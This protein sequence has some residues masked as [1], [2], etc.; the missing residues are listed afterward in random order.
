MS[1]LKM[2]RKKPEVVLETF[3]FSESDE[4]R[5]VGQSCSRADL[6]KA[7]NVF[8]KHVREA[9][10]AAELHCFAVQQTADLVSVD[11][12]YNIKQEVVCP[13]AENDLF[14]TDDMHAFLEDF[15]DVK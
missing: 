3:H 4:S 9:K 11:T 15:F 13:E 5:V 14:T 10:G 1:S 7:C 12:P 2:D 6:P 8:D